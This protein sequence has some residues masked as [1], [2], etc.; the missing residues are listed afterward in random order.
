MRVEVPE[1]L[2]Q[3]Q[4]HLRVVL[5]SEDLEIRAEHT[6]HTDAWRILQI[7]AVFRHSAGGVHNLPISAA[8]E[9]DIHR[10]RDR[11]PE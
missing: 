10:R 9:C 1:G 8:I 4:R 5:E 2:L 6:G 11:V 3:Q 7:Q